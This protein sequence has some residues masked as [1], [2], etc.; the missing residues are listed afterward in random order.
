MLVYR[1]YVKENQFQFWVTPR[2]CPGN[3]WEIC[4]LIKR[5][6]RKFFEI[7]APDFYIFAYLPDLLKHL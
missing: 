2:N 4:H 3:I 6:N 5:T 7:K 1:V